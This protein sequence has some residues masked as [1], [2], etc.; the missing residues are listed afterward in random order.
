MPEEDDDG[1]I[2]YTRK[3]GE[4][5]TYLLKLNISIYTPHV[6]RSNKFIVLLISLYSY[7]KAL[8]TSQNIFCR[9]YSIYLK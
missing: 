9:I 8:K 4:F 1:M 5:G 2:L 6:Q 3:Y 7:T